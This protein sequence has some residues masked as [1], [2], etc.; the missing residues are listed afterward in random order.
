MPAETLEV[1][2][3]AACRNTLQPV[4]LGGLQTSPR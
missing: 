3:L 1:V 2:K 4:V